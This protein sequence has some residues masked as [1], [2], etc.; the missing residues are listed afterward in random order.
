MPY[1]RGKWFWGAF[2][3]G[4][5]ER[6][7]VPLR[8]NRGRRIPFNPDPASHDYQKA[9]RAEERAKEKAERGEIAARSKKRNPLARLPFSQACEK[10][11]EERRFGLARLSI[12]TERERSRNPRAY[13]GKRLVNT[14]DADDLREYTVWRKQQKPL[15]GDAAEVSNRTVN[16]EVAFVRRLLKRAGRLRL[17]GDLPKFLPERHDVGRALSPEER[18]RLLKTAGLKAEWRLAR[19]A[20]TL[21]EN[22]TMRSCEIKGLQWRDIDLINRELTVSVSKTEGGRFRRIPLNTAAYAAIMELRDR[23][24]VWFGGEPLPDWYVF[25]RGP[26]QGPKIGPNQATVK[27][28]PTQPLTSWRSAWRAI[29]ATAAKGD[30]D[31]GIPP[32]PSLKT[33]RFHDLRHD[34]ISQ[35]AEGPASDMTVMAIA[36]H[37]SKK[38]LE[39]YS[40]IRTEAKRQALDAIST[41]T[42]PPAKPEG[43]GLPKVP[44]TF[45]VTNPESAGV[46]SSQLLD[47]VGGD[48]G[49]RT[50][51]LC[52]DSN[53]K[54]FNGTDSPS[55]ETQ[56]A[57]CH[58]YRTLI[59]P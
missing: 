12:R 14:I 2:S 56:G 27:P 58:D 10:F 43:T 34:A 48:D 30:P 32:M 26:G 31:K 21:S 23:A 17:L 54:E 40:H 19:L 5:G 46:P 25:P 35:L 22:T 20:L 37:V 11:L 7:R 39:H 47:S 55:W 29:R 6:F 57:E 3:T 52:R 51:G 33:L 28:D 8:D 36:G 24:K 4:D 45:S 38:M 44:V 13:F 49:T 41:P 9:A 42:A 1:Q 15:R 16:M 50:R 53:L 59:G 18:A